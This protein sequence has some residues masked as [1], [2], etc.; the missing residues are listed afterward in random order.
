MGLLS[1]T[2]EDDAV[3]KATGLAAEPVFWSLVGLSAFSGK[4]G[5]LDEGTC[6]GV[7]GASDCAGRFAGTAFATAGSGTLK[8]REGV[9]TGVIL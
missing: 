8:T 2:G 4:D 1:L 6:R 7:S 5:R 3:G 9:G